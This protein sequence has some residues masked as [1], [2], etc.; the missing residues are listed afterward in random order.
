MPGSAVTMPS[1]ASPWVV[2]FVEQMMEEAASRWCCAEGRSVIPDSS[3]N[4]K[5]CRNFGISMKKSR[6]KKVKPRENED[7]V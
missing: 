7:V 5:E 1:P 6:I 2:A 4:C 3:S